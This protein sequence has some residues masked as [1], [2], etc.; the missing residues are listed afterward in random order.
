MKSRS[1]RLEC[2]FK[3]RGIDRLENPTFARGEHGAPKPGHL[4]AVAP[5]EISFLWACAVNKQTGK[6]EPPALI[7]K[8]LTLKDFMRGGWPTLGMASRLDFSGGRWRAL[9]RVSRL[10]LQGAALFAPSAKG[11]C[12]LRVFV[13]AGGPGFDG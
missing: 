6:P 1:P 4:N 2:R 5:A 8:P 10:E 3:F 11:A 7:G 13:R 12:L 9:G